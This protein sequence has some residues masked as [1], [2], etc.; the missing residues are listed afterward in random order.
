MTAE[1]AK[2]SEFKLEVFFHSSVGLWMVDFKDFRGYGIR[3][4]GPELDETVEKG[5]RHLLRTL[6]A[7]G[8]EKL[9]F[10]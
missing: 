10:I 8:L 9:H 6:K 1:I 2:P 3:E 4:K 7:E 5:F